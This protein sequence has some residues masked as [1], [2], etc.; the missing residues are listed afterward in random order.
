MRSKE[1]SVYFSPSDDLS[2]RIIELIS[3]ADSTIKVAMYNLKNERVVKS[4]ID[5]R[6]RGVEVSI[7]VDGKK[8]TEDVYS[9]MKNNG[10][11]LNVIHESKMH[12]KFAIFDRLHVVT[13]SFNWKEGVESEYDNIIIIKNKKV[14]T[15]Y[16]NEFNNLEIDSVP[17]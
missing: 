5:A 11:N 12:N 17:M 8:I 2:V 13:G 1:H 16:L 3:K 6:R 7:I 9:S 10:I 14:V 15:Q 4:L